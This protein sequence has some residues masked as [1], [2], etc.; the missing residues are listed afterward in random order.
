MKSTFKIGNTPVGDGAPCYVIAEIGSNHNQDF[1]LALKHIDAA[2]AAGVDAVKFQT[3]KASTHISGMPNRP[4]I[5]T[6]RI[7]MS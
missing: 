3:F 7:S 5:S 2:A 6:R 1:A 4:P